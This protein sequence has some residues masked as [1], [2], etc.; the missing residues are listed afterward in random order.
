MP[1]PDQRQVRRRGN[2][3]EGGDGWTV[4]TFPLLFP[5]SFSLFLFLPFS[6]LLLARGALGSPPRT[7]HGSAEDRWLRTRSRSHIYKNS[8]CHYPFGPYTA[9][10]MCLI[11]YTV[12]LGLVHGWDADCKTPARAR[13]QPQLQ[14]QQR[15]TKTLTGNS[16]RQGRCS[17]ELPGVAITGGTRFQQYQYVPCCR[18]E[19][20]IV[21]NVH[22]TWRERLVG[23]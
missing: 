9:G 16:R 1:A 11:Y 12:N 2:A 17:T 23:F 21:S 6:S 10:W 3:E 7:P 15:T 19:Q 4:P 13:S 14:L 20:G 8:S 22:H 18:G 5:L